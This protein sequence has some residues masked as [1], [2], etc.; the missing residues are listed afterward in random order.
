M[1]KGIHPLLHADLLHVLASMGHGDEL[2]IADAN[3]PSATNGKRLV[4]LAAPST[5][6]ALEAII[7]LFPVDASA[8]PPARDDVQTMSPNY[9]ATR[10]LAAMLARVDHPSR[11]S[12]STARLLCT[13]PQ[14]LRSCTA[15]LRIS[16]TS[17]DQSSEPVSRLK[18]RWSSSSAHTDL[19]CRVARF[20]APGGRPRLILHDLS[21]AK[22]PARP[23]PP[24]VPGADGDWARGGEATRSA[25]RHVGPI[26]GGVNVEGVARVDAPTGCATI[27]VDDN[28]E[29]CIVVVAG[30]NAKADPHAVPD[31]VLTNETVLVLQQEVDVAANAAL[32]ARARRASVRIVLNAAPAHAVSL[33]LLRQLDLL[34]VNEAE[35][36]ALAT[37]LGWAGTPRDFATRARAASP[38]LAVV[39][40]LGAAGALWFGP[41][42]TLRAAPPKIRVIDTTGAGDAFVGALWRHSTPALPQSSPCDM[43]S[44]RARS[45][46]WRMEHS[47][48]CQCGQRSTRCYLRLQSRAHDAAIIMHPSSHATIMLKRFLLCAFLLA[49]AFR[50][51]AVDYTDLYYVPGEEGW[52]ANVVQSDDFLFV[53]FFIYGSDNKPT[54]YTA[55]LTLDAGGN[56]NG[57]LYA[58]TGTYY[59]MPWKAS[60][61]TT[62]AVGTASFQPTSAYT[63]K[64]IYVV[65]TPAPAGG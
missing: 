10:E 28:G 50:V 3:F 32:I 4:Q 1:L 12:D 61:Q 44:R 34:I 46:A 53:T 14:C 54:W 31:A 57:Q 29:N 65:T 43:A 5:T 9:S 39:V 13:C 35:A 30:A 18:S 11:R 17:Y 8:T 20:P 41:D 2:V 56:Y 15:D 60:D 59:A 21:G 49:A 51:G 25:A 7:T 47:R 48:R 37:A 64:L 40:T 62:V 52:G 45:R 23:W 16:P 26:T 19:V 6:V 27:L 63:A 55:Q 33:D 58:T 38:D 24:R 22:A 42:A 36:S